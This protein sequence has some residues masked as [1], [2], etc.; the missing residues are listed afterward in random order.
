MAAGAPASQAP[1]AVPPP[2]AIHATPIAPQHGPPMA[3]P[4]AYSQQPQQ[5]QIVYVQAPPNAYP[6]GYYAQNQQH[7]QQSVHVRVGGGGC[8]ASLFKLVGALGCM[9]C[10]GVFFAFV[11][12]AVGVEAGGVAFVL[13]IVFLFVFILGR[14]FE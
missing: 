11:G 14:I 4:I 7:V 2:Q 12:G 13:G 9:V 5:P 3:Q 8:L 10:A 6:P 1:A